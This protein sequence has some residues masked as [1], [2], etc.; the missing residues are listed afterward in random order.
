MK[1]IDKL[2]QICERNKWFYFTR[3][4]GDAMAHILLL[5]E[6]L[7]VIASAICGEDRF[8]N[9]NGFIEISGKPLESD[10]VKE[11]LT[12]DQ[13]EKIWEKYA[14]RRDA[15]TTGGSWSWG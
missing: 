12:A 2:A 7:K 9:T 6:D 8:T 11:G 5:N 15:W 13:V 10:E 4:R 14:V 1:E 3:F